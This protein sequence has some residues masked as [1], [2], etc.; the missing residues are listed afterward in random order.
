[1]WGAISDERRG[2]SFAIAAGSRR[3]N[4]SRV[5][6]SGGSWQYFTVSDLRLNNLEDQS[7]SYFTTGGL[8]PISFFLVISPLRF[9]TNNF[10]ST[11]HLRS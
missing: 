5:L 2:L 9:T 3:P 11:E 8:P 6:V 10:F 1:M 4:H 7:Q